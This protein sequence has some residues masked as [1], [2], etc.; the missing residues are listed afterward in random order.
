MTLR[1]WEQRGPRT[2]LAALAPAGEQGVSVQQGLIWHLEP[3]GLGGKGGSSPTPLQGVGS[4]AQAESSGSL[5]LKSQDTS[6]TE[7]RGELSALP[8][9]SIEPMGAQ[10]PLHPHLT[11]G[12]QLGGLLWRVHVI[13]CPCGMPPPSSGSLKA[14]TTCNSSYTCQVLQLEKPV[15]ELEGLASTPDRHRSHPSKYNSA[16][17]GPSEERLWLTWAR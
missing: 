8:I 15:P 6:V 10:R 5:K 9:G 1:P 7:N 11:D 3:L 14:T 4:G 16:L 12:T 17:E 13:I 2:H